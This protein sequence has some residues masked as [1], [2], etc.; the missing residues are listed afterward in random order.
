MTN[1]TTVDNITQFPSQRLAVPRVEN[2]R[3][4]LFDTSQKNIAQELIDL[5]YA[6]IHCALTLAKNKLKLLNRLG[7]AVT[8]RDSVTDPFHFAFQRFIDYFRSFHS[9][10]RYTR[11]PTDNDL[12]EMA[13]FTDEM[14]FSYKHIVLGYLASKKK[15]K[16]LAVSLYNALYYIGQ[17]MLQSYEQNQWQNSR[18]WQEIHFLYAYAE[19]QGFL[20]QDI[21]SNAPTPRPKS[22]DGL[23]KQLLLTALADPYKMTQ[24]KHWAVFDYS[25]RIAQHAE[26]QKPEALPAFNYGF[27]IRLDSSKPPIAVRALPQI[28]HTSLRILLP[29]GAATIINR[30]LEMIKTGQS[31]NI[32]GLS[33]TARDEDKIRFLQLLHHQWA[34][35]PLR[36]EKR[37][38]TKESI[39][40]IWGVKDIHK[41]LDPS[42]RHQATMMQRPTSVEHSSI[43]LSQN[44]STDGI[45]ITLKTPENDAPSNGQVVGLIR[46]INNQKQL[47]LGIIQW[48]AKRGPR[49]LVCGVK[50]LFSAPQPAFVAEQ[51][52]PDNTYPAL[53]FRDIDKHGDTNT[54]LLASSG[55]LAPGK[56]ILVNLINTQNW[57]STTSMSPVKQTECIDLFKLQ[58]AI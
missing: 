12:M 1:S 24:G 39:G 37:E 48:S 25:G 30:Q 4:I 46:K 41:I 52:N 53:L 27:A 28:P 11:P 40:F 21:P 26:I 3:H 7:L 56:A 35:K 47:T 31:Q 58:G 42:A 18:L 14:A 15:Q 2:T 55:L 23:Y 44:E 43:G 51:N 10:S 50:K 54:Q 17:S 38:L 8:K 16:G 20:G 34:E 45:C 32:P 57:H 13:L 22:I 49:Q 29:Q 33:S 19:E 36:N 5:P 9:L 6:D